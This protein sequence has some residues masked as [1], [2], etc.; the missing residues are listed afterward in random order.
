MD[1][2]LMFGPSHTDDLTTGPRFVELVLEQ[3]AFLSQQLPMA[4]TLRSVHPD[5]IKYY[6]AVMLFGHALDSLLARCGLT[7]LRSELSAQ[8][9]SEK[10]MSLSGE[11][12]FAPGLHFDRKCGF[13]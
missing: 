1:G 9:R 12:A 7:C 10:F 13:C 4:Q 6:E 8:I 3:R 11:I 2:M 5:A